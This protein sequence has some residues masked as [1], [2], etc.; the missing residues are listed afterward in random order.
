LSNIA[1]DNTGPNSVVYAGV[2]E[3]GA[4]SGFSGVDVSQNNNETS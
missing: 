3:V 4:E 2:G 1:V